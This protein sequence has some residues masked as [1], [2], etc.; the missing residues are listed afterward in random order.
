MEH[1]ITIT[2]I[3]KNE[4][5]QV[6]FSLVLTPALIPQLIQAGLTMLVGMGI[7]QFREVSREEFEALPADDP[8]KQEASM[9][10][11]Q[12]ALWGPLLGMDTPTDPKD[13]N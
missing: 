5:G 2:K 10:P 11:E 8:I 6:E 4:D 1:P 7:A 13:F 12:K 3:V 9:S